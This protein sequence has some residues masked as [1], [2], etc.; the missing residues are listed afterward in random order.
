MQIDKKTIRRIFLGAAGCIFLYW[1]LHETNR[2]AQVFRFFGDILS[3]FV[4]GALLAFVLNVPMRGIESR[5]KSIQKKG[6]RRGVAML[7]TF[8]LVILVLVGVVSLLVPQIAQTGERL[9]TVSLPAFFERSQ[10]WVQKQLEIHPE[11][12]EWLEDNT[13][14]EK[15][16][17]ASL[18]QRAM[19]LIS[20]GLTTVWGTLYSFLIG[21]GSGLFNAVLSIIFAIYCLGRKELLA[22]QGKQ[23]LYSV[24]PEHVCDEIIRILRMTNSTFSNFISGQTL[25]AC[26][27]AC[28]FALAMVIFR[29]PYAALVSVVIGVTALIPIV[30]AFAG[31]IVGAFFIMVDSVPQALGFIVLFLAL[32]QIENNLIYPKVVGTSI[33]L[34]GMWVLVAVAVGGGLAGIVGMLLMIPLA[35]V[36]YSLLREY[37]EGR[38]AA[39]GIAPE[40]LEALPPEEHHA[41]TGG[42][43][44]PVLAQFVPKKLKERLKNRKNTP[45]KK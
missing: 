33:G 11:L 19:S 9:V 2:V 20:S 13:D 28:M 25:E 15:M 21:L 18:I 36:L 3:P 1:L 7:L 31:C 26:I 37:T 43:K 30:G 29:M 5:L 12:L 16:D 42:K 41:A 27:L 14:F 23:I 32:Q 39:K 6:L 45:Q 40:K 44:P 4:A 22:K 35:S 38:L 17:W 24:L 34:P 10:V 8:V